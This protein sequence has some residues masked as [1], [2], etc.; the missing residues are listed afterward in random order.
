MTSQFDASL[1]YSDPISPEVLADQRQAVEAAMRM[2][3]ALANAKLHAENELKRL[4]LACN[5]FVW[6][7]MPEETRA[8][9]PE[10]VG[11]MMEHFAGEGAERLRRDAK[12][13]AEQRNLVA[14]LAE[15]ESAYLLRVA[16]EETENARREAERLELE[17]F[18]AYDA[19][20]KQQRFEAWRALRRR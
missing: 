12:L 15:A 18:E 14:Q 20:G 11:Q 2:P 1:A 19:A 6:G 7:S 4:V 10:E 3:S 16:A 13:A 5:R 9:T 8:P 17:E